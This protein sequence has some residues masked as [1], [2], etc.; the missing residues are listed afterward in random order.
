MIGRP[1]A[2]R[3]DTLNNESFHLPMRVIHSHAHM[4]HD[5]NIEHVIIFSCA[6]FIPTGSELGTCKHS[7]N[8]NVEHASHAF[9]SR[10]HISH[11]VTAVGFYERTGNDCVY[12][13]TILY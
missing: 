12:V 6:S 5:I 4:V 7:R 2:H 13:S 11:L 9:S 1:T 3:P 8:V 10:S